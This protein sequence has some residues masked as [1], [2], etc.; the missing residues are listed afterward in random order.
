[1]RN[2]VTIFKLPTDLPDLI[3]KPPNMYFQWNVLYFSYTY[4]VILSSSFNPPPFK[5]TFYSILIIML[6]VI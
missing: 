6:L 1:M 4:P 2:C 3:S 5:F